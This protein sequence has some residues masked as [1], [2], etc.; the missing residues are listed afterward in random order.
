M[1][2]E[3]KPPCSK[4]IPEDFRVTFYDG[5]RNDAGVLGAKAVGEQSLN[6]GVSV[7]F[8]LRR[9]ID[10]V[11]K[12]LGISSMTWYNLGGPATPEVL[13]TTTGVTAANFIL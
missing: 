2:Q 6:M 10:A 12:D 13:Q 8:A 9:A 11:R 3:Y 5:K 1:I 4:D 7:I